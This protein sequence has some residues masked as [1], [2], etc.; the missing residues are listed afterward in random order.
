MWTLYGVNLTMLGPDLDPNCFFF[1]KRNQLTTTNAFDNTLKIQLL[2]CT[3]Y[4]K[5][6]NNNGIDKLMHMVLRRLFL[7]ACMCVLIK[8]ISVYYSIN[9]KNL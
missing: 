7:S 3:K 1:R 2:K 6:A 5:T 9:D 4:H 8:M